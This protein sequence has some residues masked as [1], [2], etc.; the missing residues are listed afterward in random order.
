MHMAI[1]KITNKNRMTILLFG[2]PYINIIRTFSS[3][4]LQNL[5]RNL[6]HI[7]LE[8]VLWTSKP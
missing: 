6:L 4:N 7:K 2:T 1:A 3:E 5:E 8:G